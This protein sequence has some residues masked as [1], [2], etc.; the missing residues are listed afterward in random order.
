MQMVWNEN[1]HHSFG[2]WQA[3]LVA[4]L[5]FKYLVSS[6]DT[7]QIM[8]WIMEMKFDLGAFPFLCFPKELS[9]WM[10]LQGILK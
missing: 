1:S 4:Q 10:I 8:L 5:F 7:C 2:R 3:S 6:N 9:F